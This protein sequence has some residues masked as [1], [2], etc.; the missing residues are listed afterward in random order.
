MQR[1]FFDSTVISSLQIEVARDATGAPILW[2]VEWASGE[3]ERHE[4]LDT[5]EGYPSHIAGSCLSRR[6]EH[7]FGRKAA[8]AAIRKLGLSNADYTSIGVGS[9]DEPT[10]PIGIVGSISHCDHAAIAAVARRSQYSGVGID[11]ETVV[12]QEQAAMLARVSTNER[13]MLLLCGSICN[14]WDICALTTLTFSAKESLYKSVFPFVGAS[15]DFLVA[16]RLV[17]LNLERQELD[18]ELSHSLCKKLSLRSRYRVAF[19]RLSDDVIFTH[20]VW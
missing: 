4:H 9:F 13:E 14:S 12:S 18:L 10:W 20:V 15:F 8:I 6:A 11:V 17:A 16:T 1:P 5:S 19:E 7:Y 2:L 3:I